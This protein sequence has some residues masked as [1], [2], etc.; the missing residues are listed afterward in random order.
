MEWNSLLNRT[1]ELEFSGCRCYQ[2]E[3]NDLNRK[4]NKFPIV[5]AKHPKMKRS[6]NSS[7]HTCNADNC[8]DNHKHVFMNGLFP[9]ERAF[10]LIEGKK[11]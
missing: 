4:R 11:N 6:S 10:A 9:V 1:L 5:K 2:T 3:L 8:S 7:I